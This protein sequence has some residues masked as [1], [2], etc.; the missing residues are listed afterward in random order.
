MLPPRGNPEAG[1]PW[2]RTAAC[3]RDPWP[4]FALA[5]GPGADL[6]AQ[7]PALWRR[8]PAPAAVVR[9][10]SAT[11]GAAGGRVAGG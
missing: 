8:R 7:L 1:P 9:H 6:G 11:A 3:P 4:A 10:L 2:A 5:L